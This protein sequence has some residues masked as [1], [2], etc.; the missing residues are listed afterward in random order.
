MK[1][2]PVTSSN[3]S[4][5]GYDPDAKALHVQYK[6]GATYIY[7]GVPQA[8]YDALKGASSVGTHLHAHIKGRFSHSKSG[9]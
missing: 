7:S 6:S 2:E 1:L 5:I 8:S 9:A 4:A 3:V